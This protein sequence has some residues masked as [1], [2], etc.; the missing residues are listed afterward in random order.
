MILRGDFHLA[1][2]EVLYRLVGAAMTEFE[3]EGLATQRQAHHLVPQADAE[4][5]LFSQQLAHRFDRRSAAPQDRPGPLERKTPSGLTGQ[6]LFGRRVGGKD[7]DLAA[8]TLQHAQDVVLDP[9]VQGRHP[10]PRLVRDQ[11]LACSVAR[12]GSSATTGRVRAGDILNQ[13]DPVQSGKGL[14]LVP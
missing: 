4:H 10:K 13:V 6:D 2:S 3:L 9:A 12:W 1:G 11:A 7:H 14:H 5:R 8:R